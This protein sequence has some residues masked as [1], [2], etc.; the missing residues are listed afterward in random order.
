MSLEDNAQNDDIKNMPEDI[1]K[2][3]KDALDGLQTTMEEEL[4]GKY[5]SVRASHWI[6]KVCEACMEKLIQKSRPFKYVVTCLIMRRNGA[7]IHVCSAALWSQDTDNCVCEVFDMVNKPTY[8]VVT[9]YWVA[10]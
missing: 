5:D 8:A 6:N 10:V 1:K 2:V 7:G 4:E 3:V 9:V